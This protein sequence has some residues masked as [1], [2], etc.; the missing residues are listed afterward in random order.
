[1]DIVLDQVTKRYGQNTIL[2]GVSSTFRQGR[3]VALIG[4]S[5]GGKSTLLRCINGLNTYDAGTIS[6]GEHCLPCGPAGASSQVTQSV[7]K[8]LGMVFQ[9]FRLF[10]HLT[11]IE[12]VMEA[13]IQVLG[14]VP[15]VARARAKELLER[16]GL[17]HRGDHYPSQL[18]GGQQQRVAIARALAM[19][20]RGLLCDEITSALDPELKGEIL[21]VLI[22]LRSEGLTLI[23]VTHEMGFARKAADHVAVLGAGKI[24]EEGPPDQ[25]FE[26][27]QVE[28]TK[29]FLSRV[30]A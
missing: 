1:M 21:D 16:V 24:L 17:G 13:P 22:D 28:R 14:Q 25:I 18:S 2:D 23:V 11:A 6:V 30:L 12:N 8:L 4:P 5:G 20:P 26:A 27:P 3:T 10:P 19:E 15:E 29:Q 7:R 9:D